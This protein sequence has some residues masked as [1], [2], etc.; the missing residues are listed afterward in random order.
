M[1]SSGGSSLVRRASRSAARSRC[2]ADAQRD[3]VSHRPPRRA[4]RGGRV[5]RPHAISYADRVRDAGV[6]LDQDPVAQECH[7][8]PALDRPRESRLRSRPSRRYRRPRHRTPPTSTS[9]PVMSRRNPSAYPTGTRAIQVGSRPRRT[10]ARSPCS[11]P[12]PSCFDACDLG[13]PAQRGPQAPAGS[14]RRR[15]ARSRRGRSRSARRRAA[16]P[17]GASAAAL[18]AACRVRCG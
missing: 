17:A 2:S 6:L 4:A 3:G 14:G 13:L 1:P 15:T 5:F 18:F 9:V 8:C 10:G 7:G 12:A 11:R 16:R